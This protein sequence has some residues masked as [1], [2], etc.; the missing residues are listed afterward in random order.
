MG[1]KERRER[2]RGELRGLIMD[3]ARE[4]LA[5]EGYEAISMRKLADAIEYSPTAIYAYFTDKEELFRQI[6]MDDFDR[7]N[8]SQTSAIEEPDPVK[9]IRLVGEMYVRFAVE[10][11]NHFRRMFLDPPHV[12]LSQEQL[13]RRGD[14]SHDGYAFFRGTVAEAVAAGRFVPKL[15]ND[16]DLITQTLWAA[17]HGI[18]A[19]LVVHGDDDSWVKLKPPEQ[20]TQTMLDTV[21][22]TMLVPE[23]TPVAQTPAETQK[24]HRTNR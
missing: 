18:A 11:P 10:H 22:V 19:I 9:R 17:V 20:L 1:S 15:G 23:P 14:P 13:A 12:S 16:I 7:F 8:A 6:C 24:T 2:E 5:R 21:L 4:M 3:A